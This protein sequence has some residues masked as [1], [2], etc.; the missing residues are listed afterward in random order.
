MHKKVD[1][2]VFYKFSNIAAILAAE[3]NFRGTYDIAVASNPSESFS[4]LK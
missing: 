3:I 2:S 1:F 4:R